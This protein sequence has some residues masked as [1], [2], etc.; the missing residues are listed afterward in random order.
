VSFEAAVSMAR[1]GRL[2]PAVILHGS[3]DDRRRSAALELGRTLLCESSAGSRPCGDCRH[4]RR[5]TT[6]ADGD[7]FHPDFHLLERDQKTVTSIEATRQFLQAAQMAPY[8]ARGQVFV[9][10]SAESLGPEAADT[11]L[12]ILEEPPPRTPRNFLLLTP[13]SRELT[14]TLR[15]RSMSLFLGGGS[16]ADPQRVGELAAE[17]SHSVDGFL[18]SGATVHLL[19]AAAALERAGDWRDLRASAPWALAAAAVVE[20]NRNGEIP[21]EARRALL[22]LAADLLQARGQRVR[23]ITPQRILEGLMV[24]HLGGLSARVTGTV[25]AR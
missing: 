16:A 2:Y 18:K 22:D 24:H 19:A 7:R 23:G 12:K 13:S 3:D 14:S 15:S 4:C 21:V 6:A 8:E 10:A 9:I 20:V 1:E 17:V 5:I 11:L 25:A